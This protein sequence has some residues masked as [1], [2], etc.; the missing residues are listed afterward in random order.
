MHIYE[1]GFLVKHLFSVSHILRALVIR[2][3][4][5]LIWL[6]GYLLLRLI[7]LSSS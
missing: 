5:S 3:V 7:M 1:D 2:P 4:S 6:V